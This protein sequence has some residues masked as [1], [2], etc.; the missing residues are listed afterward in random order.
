[1]EYRRNADNQSA[2]SADSNSRQWWVMDVC[3][4]IFNSLNLYQKEV[5]KINMKT[6]MLKLKGQ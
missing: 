1:M 4:Q 6:F 5:L 3:V 2:F